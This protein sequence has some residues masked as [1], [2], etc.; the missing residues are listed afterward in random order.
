MPQRIVRPRQS[1]RSTAE[2]IQSH[3]SIFRQQQQ[4]FE[5]LLHGASDTGSDDRRAKSRQLATNYDFFGAPVGLINSTLLN[6]S[7]LDCGLVLQTLMRAAV[8][9]GYGTC[10]QTVLARHEPTIV[11]ELHFPV[12]R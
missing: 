3:R 4:E 10:A 1:W 6:D 5:A 9:R 7:W 11:Q 8:A 12:N 2:T